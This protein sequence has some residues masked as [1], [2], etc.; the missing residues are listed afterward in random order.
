MQA[1]ST[2]VRIT[3]VGACEMP[4]QQAGGAVLV[5]DGR[6]AANDAR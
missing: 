1:Y 6:D 5:D 3:S 4:G 2:A